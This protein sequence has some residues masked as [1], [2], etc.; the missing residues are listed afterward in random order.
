M[1]SAFVLE[2]DLQLP[3]SLVSFTRLLLLPDGEWTKTRDKGKIPK[4]KIDSQALSVILKVLRKR[5]DE[6]PTTME[7]RFL[8]GYDFRWVANFKVL[9]RRQ[10]IM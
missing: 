2:T 9:V 8:S 10:H 5:L 6:Y 1:N 4:P 3:Q 7:V